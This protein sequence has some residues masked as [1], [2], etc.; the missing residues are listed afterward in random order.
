MFDWFRRYNEETYDQFLT[1]ILKIKDDDKFLL[2]CWKG[3]PRPYPPRRG[4]PI[5]LYSD[6]GYILKEPRLPII[7]FE[8]DCEHWWGA[9]VKGEPLGYYYIP[10]W[11]GPV[12]KAEL[13]RLIRLSFTRYLDDVK[14][15]KDCRAEFE[16][17]VRA[18]ARELIGKER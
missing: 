4:N 14:S 2:A 12:I 17:S 7:G 10:D 15:E 11:V 1:R 16:R 18:E 8:I 9:T 6:V 5:N 3:R 13:V